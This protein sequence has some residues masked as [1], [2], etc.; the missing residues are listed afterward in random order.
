MIVKKPEAEKL[1]TKNTKQEMLNAYYTLLQ[2]VEQR[3]QDQLKPEK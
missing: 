3:N 1:T 2:E